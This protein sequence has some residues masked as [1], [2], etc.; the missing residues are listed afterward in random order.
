VSPASCSALALRRPDPGLAEH[1]HV[2]TRPGSIISAS[3]GAAG[4]TS[5]SCIPCWRASAW[6][7]CARQRSGRGLRATT[8]CPSRDPEG[9]RLEVNHVLDAPRG[10]GSHGR[11]AGRAG[12]AVDGETKTTQAAPP[13][14]RSLASRHSG[15]RLPP[16]R[17]PPARP[18][19]RWR[20]HARRASRRSG[21][22]S[23]A[24]RGRRT[25]GRCARSRFPPHI[26]S[27]EFPRLM[28]CR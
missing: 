9:I 8:R 17:S 26:G 12:R 23:C 25:R 13:Y 24:T 18:P 28:A 3:A 20:S 4:R 15:R 14:A 21:P 6:T 22:R 5:T 10:C 27:Q 19:R 1:A 7:S 2:E 11:R 16:R